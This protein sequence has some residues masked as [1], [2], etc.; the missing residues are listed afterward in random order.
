MSS[1]SAFWRWDAGCVFT[2][3]NLCDSGMR[4]WHFDYLQPYPCPNG[5]PIKTG[6][7]SESPAWRARLERARKES[8]EWD[9]TIRVREAAEAL[10]VET[11]LNDMEVIRVWARS[12]KAVL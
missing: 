2:A 12:L 1:V 4:G 5:L 7:P 8:N 6:V 10:T 11:I 9:R 3:S